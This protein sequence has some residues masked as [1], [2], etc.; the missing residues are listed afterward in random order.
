M[1]PA[2]VIWIILA[3]A[4]LV[5]E[6]FNDGKDRPKAFKDVLIHTLVMAI[7]LAWGGFFST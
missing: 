3:L 5:S 7:L 6:A 2:A 4:T 1:H